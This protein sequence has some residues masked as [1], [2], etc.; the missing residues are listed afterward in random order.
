MIGTERLTENVFY[1]ALVE[2]SEEKTAERF[3]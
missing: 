1:R 2:G 3:W